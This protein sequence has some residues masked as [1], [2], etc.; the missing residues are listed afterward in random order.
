VEIFQ[1]ARPKGSNNKAETSGNYD[2]AR[3]IFF[4]SQSP[5]PSLRV[6]RIPPLPLLV[7]PFSFF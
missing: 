2:S 5:L 6:I 4:L 3:P 1:N 7:P